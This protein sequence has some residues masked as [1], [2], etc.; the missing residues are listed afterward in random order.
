[1]TIQRAIFQCTRSPTGRPMH[2][3]NTDHLPSLFLRALLPSFLFSF[4]MFS[5]LSLFS[6]LFFCLC[7]VLCFLRHQIVIATTAMVQWST[8]ELNRYSGY[9][10]VCVCLQCVVKCVLLCVPLLVCM[11]SWLFP[12]LISY[13]FNCWY[14]MR[15]MSKILWNEPHLKNKYGFRSR[16]VKIK[17]Y[18]IN[19]RMIVCMGHD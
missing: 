19:H 6:L 17:A 5:L 8:A 14:C 16:R 12:W 15:L 1:M 3:K 13:G 2:Q 4:K 18:P 7:C 10:C 11:F 9:L